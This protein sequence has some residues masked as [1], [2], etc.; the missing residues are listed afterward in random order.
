[1]SSWKI[2]LTRLY[3]IPVLTLLGILF[4]YFTLYR[5]NFVSLWLTPDQQAYKLYE[6][7][8][9][10]KAQTLFKDF[11]FKAASYYKDHN[12]TQAAIIYKEINTTIAKYNQAN[13][14]T[15]FGQYKRAVESYNKAL[16]EE[17]NFKEAQQNIKVAQRL[18]KEKE[19]INE[20]T[21]VKNPDKNVSVALTDKKKNEKKKKNKRK[22]KKQKI[23]MPGVA[24]WLDRLSTTPKDFLRQKFAYEYAKDKN[25]TK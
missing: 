11:A 25:E 9:Y 1:M 14:L 10:K 17:P 3:F 7:K 8:E 18:L 21:I 15:M 16:K 23:Q 24:L 2:F 4:W 19:Y 6:K 13:A 20:H 22:G 12:F 5:S